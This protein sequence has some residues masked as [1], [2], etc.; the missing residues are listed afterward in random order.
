MVLAILCRTMINAG[1]RLYHHFLS[2]LNCGNN[3][4][5]TN[6]TQQLQDTGAW[7]N[8]CDC[9]YLDVYI[10]CSLNLK[11]TFQINIEI[12]SGLRHRFVWPK[13]YYLGRAINTGYEV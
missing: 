4:E 1:H 7:S 8:G 9:V 11:K 5:I 2:V 10:H 12:T 13:L 6:L 3:R